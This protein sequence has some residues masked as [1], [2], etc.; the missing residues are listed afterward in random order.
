ME[1]IKK[2]NM[3]FLN[4]LTAQDRDEIYRYLWAQHVKEDIKGHAEDIDDDIAPDE[5]ERAAY[6]YVYEG[7]YDCTLNY[8]TNI[9]NVIIRATADRHTEEWRNIQQNVAH[10]AQYHSRYYD[11]E[12][13]TNTYYLTCSSSIILYLW[14]D[15]HELFDMDGAMISIEIPVGAN[16]C[17]FGTICVAPLNG[18]RPGTW[19]DV[20]FDGNTVEKLLDIIEEAN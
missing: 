10:S 8:W 20:D 13:E 18:G 9:E 1:L 17:A 11:E 4:S 3:D 16:D 6:L 5:I 14:A 12:H 15:T 19:I 7:Q 2:E